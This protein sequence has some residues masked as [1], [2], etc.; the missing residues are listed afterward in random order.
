MS[1]RDRQRADAVYDELLARAG[2]AWVQPRMERTARL[3]ELL[4]DPQRS[5]RVI[6]ITGTNG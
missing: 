6:H 5:Y 4:G 2:E 1:D 3:L